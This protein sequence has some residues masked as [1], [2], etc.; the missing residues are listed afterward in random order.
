MTGSRN[1]D[2]GTRSEGP[3]DS[4]YGRAPNRRLRDRRSLWITAGAFAVVLVGWV[5][6]VGLGASQPLLETRDIRNVVQDD[7]NVT[8][9]FEASIPV[10]SPA[11]CAVEALNQSFAVVGWK[12]IDL[13]PSDQYSRTFTEQL[14]TSEAATT[15][16][17]Y[18]CWL[19]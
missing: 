4:R 19:T 16:L 18:R 10:G 9:T 12:V 15:G 14:L 5:V 6:W 17:I 13:P 8:V 1:V 11:S 2:S 3:L 7:R